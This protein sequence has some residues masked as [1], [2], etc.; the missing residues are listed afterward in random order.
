MDFAI[1]G[2]IGGGVS[3]SELCESRGSLFPQRCEGRAGECWSGRL[4]QGTG[5]A[6][7]D[8][9]VSAASRFFYH[10]DWTDD[11]TDLL[12]MFADNKRVLSGERRCA[13][14]CN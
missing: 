14:G 1:V 10:E 2:A 5:D 4:A 13:E 6:A 11:S 7:V 3:L 12:S 8:L 9:S